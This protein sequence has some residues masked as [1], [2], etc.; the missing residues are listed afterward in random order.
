[1]HQVGRDI[2]DIM[3]M[4]LFQKQQKM[5]MLLPLPV[6]QQDEIIQWDEEQSHDNGQSLPAFGT[7]SST[8]N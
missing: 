3:C 7:G 6:E 4:A 2:E 1:M 8:V 5:V